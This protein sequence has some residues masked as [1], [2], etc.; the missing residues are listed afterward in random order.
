MIIW[1]G[2]GLGY[3]ND[4]FRYNPS[5]NTWNSNVSSTN[6]PAARSAHSAIWTG[7]EMII[8]G[9][10]NAGTFPY[11][12]GKRYN[13]ATNTWGA[14][15]STINAPSFRAAHVGIWTGTEMIIWGG[16][17]TSNF[18]NDGYKYNPTTNSWDV[19]QIVQ[20]NAPTI[21][22]NVSGSWSGSEMFLWGGN[23]SSSTLNNGGRFGIGPGFGSST[24]ISY[25]YYRKN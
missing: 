6:A 5:T 16:I 14:V 4:G 9:G 20:T 24:A 22:G 25:Y 19:N 1:G 17:S 8:W 3:R 2:G 13:P 10:Y 15:T 21:R 7:T 11:N 12:D 18:Y 23:N